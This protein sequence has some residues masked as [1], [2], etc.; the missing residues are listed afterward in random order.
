M[1]NLF[2]SNVARKKTLEDMES[3]LQSSKT[4]I[5]NC[6][7]RIL[8]KRNLDQLGLLNQSVIPEIEFW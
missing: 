5:E 7:K 6:A 4:R 1:K 2:G 8:D 3:L